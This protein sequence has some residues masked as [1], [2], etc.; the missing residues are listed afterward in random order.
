MC[1][2]KYVFNIGKLNK[3]VYGIYCD[4]ISRIEDLTWRN[5]CKYHTQ[6]SRVTMKR[7]FFLKRVYVGAHNHDVYSMHNDVNWALVGCGGT[8]EGNG[9][10]DLQCS[11]CLLYYGDIKNGSEPHIYYNK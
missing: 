4:F 6:V 8:P 5:T 1:V 9:V 10:A 11:N 2:K 7:I 3:D